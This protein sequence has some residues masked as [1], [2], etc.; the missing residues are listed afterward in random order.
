MNKNNINE[1]LESLGTIM[2]VRIDLIWFN[3]I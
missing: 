1:F 3:G 2:K